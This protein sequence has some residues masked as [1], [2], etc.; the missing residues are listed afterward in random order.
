MYLVSATLGSYS[1]TD[2]LHFVANEK[3]NI[4]MNEMKKKK[5]S[6]HD[7]KRKKMCKSLWFKGKGRNHVSI[8][9]EPSSAL[10]IF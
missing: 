4:T 10:D 2:C 9:F 5:E 1:S 3:N 6:V 7:I 8:S